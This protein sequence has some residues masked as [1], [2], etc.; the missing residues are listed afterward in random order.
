MLRE[1]LAA[2]E[3]SAV[4]AVVAAVSDDG[5][6]GVGM[7]AAGGACQMGKAWVA[8]SSM[9]GFKGCGATGRAKANK[10][11]ASLSDAVSFVSACSDFASETSVGGEISVALWTAVSMLSETGLVLVVFDAMVLADVKVVSTACMGGW[12]GSIPVVLPAVGKIVS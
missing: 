8:T 10:S 7:L 9:A 3:V 2:P 11:V 5:L 12:F 6:G 1:A 4:I